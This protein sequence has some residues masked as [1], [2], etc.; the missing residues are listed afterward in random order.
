M[1]KVTT[2]HPI[3]LTLHGF[4]FDYDR[5]YIIHTKDFVAGMTEYNDELTGYDLR[6]NKMYPDIFHYGG[7]AYYI[8]AH[9]IKKMGW[10]VEEIIDRA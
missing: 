9:F 3:R 10:T 1:E 4:G 5:L 7:N 6:L 2:Y 8:L